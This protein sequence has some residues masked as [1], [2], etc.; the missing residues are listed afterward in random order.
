MYMAEE[1]KVVTSE[2]NELIFDDGMIQAIEEYQS[3]EQLYQD[4]VNRVKR[5]HPSDDISLIEKAYQTSEEAHREQVR[6]SGE[7]FQS[8]KYRQTDDTF[9]PG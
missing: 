1:K 9:S 5:Y 8:K 7:P 6:K 3:P 2:K 4:L